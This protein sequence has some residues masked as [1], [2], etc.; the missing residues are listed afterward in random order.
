MKL[1]DGDNQA[2]LLLLG[3]LKVAPRRPNFAIPVEAKRRALTAGIVIGLEDAM[4]DKAQPPGLMESY[5]PSVRL[6][7]S[8]KTGSQN[9][10]AE[11]TRESVL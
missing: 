10:V 9:P 7:S 3:F 11:Q 6:L 1:A 2:R 4:T 5:R 8:N